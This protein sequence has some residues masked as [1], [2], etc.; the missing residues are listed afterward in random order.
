MTQKQLADILG[1]SPVNISQIENDYRLPQIGTLQKIGDALG[2]D[3]R[4]LPM[5]VREV[6]MYDSTMGADPYLEFY[7]DDECD[8]IDKVKLE[9][10][11]AK[12]NKAGRE[13]AVKRLEE[14]AQLTQYQSNVLH[15][16]HKFTAEEM[17]NEVELKT[18]TVQGEYIKQELPV[19]PKKKD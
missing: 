19:Y 6:T 1:I 16:R 15:P 14:L 17:G 13:E 7:H 9:A 2:V 8:D 12:L 3:W 18:D 4:T 11:Y 10:A 5:K